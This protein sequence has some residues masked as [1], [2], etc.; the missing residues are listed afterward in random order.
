MKNRNYCF[1]LHEF[2]DDCENLITEG[3]GTFVKFAIWQK[4]KGEETGAEH[5][6]GYLELTKPMRLKQV[7]AEVFGDEDSAVHL[8]SRKGTRDQA[9]SYCEKNETKLDGPWEYGKRGKTQGY[10]SDLA[11][12]EEKMKKGISMPQLVNENFCTFV[13]YSR[14]LEKAA[15]WLKKTRED[16][17]VKVYVIWGESGTGKTRAAMTGNREQIFKV[18][19]DDADK[20]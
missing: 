18:D 7:K 11:E 4:E 9:I 3:N 19:L 1:T 17:D 8:E 6:Q 16:R 15:L 5:L 20:T 13:K 2:D 14:G 12:V 10:R